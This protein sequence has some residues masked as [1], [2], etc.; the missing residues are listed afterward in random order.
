MQPGEHFVYH[1]G[2]PYHVA[3]ANNFGSSYEWTAF[4]DYHT[5]PAVKTDSNNAPVWGNVQLHI[6]RANGL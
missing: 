6:W 1:N 4:A 2:G 5:R 3:S